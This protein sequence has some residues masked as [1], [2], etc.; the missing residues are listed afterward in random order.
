MI[1]H[2]ENNDLQDM[3]MGEKSGDEYMNKVVRDDDE[4]IKG[5]E[6]ILRLLEYHVIIIIFIYWL[7]YIL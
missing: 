6:K 1:N 4:N 5:I 7:G 2:K 3:N